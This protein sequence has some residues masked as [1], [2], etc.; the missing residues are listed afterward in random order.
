ME[1][2]QTKSQEQRPRLATVTFIFQETGKFPKLF[3]QNIHQVKSLFILL[4]DFNDS[5]PSPENYKCSSEK[6]FR[7]G[8]Q[9]TPSVI[10]NDRRL[11]CFQ[12]RHYVS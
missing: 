7:M 5:K 9:I 6:I 1:N 12:A 11:V 10:F 4:K 2:K 3:L 8:Q